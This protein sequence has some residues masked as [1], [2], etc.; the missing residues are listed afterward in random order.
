MQ[1]QVEV[2]I[3]SI[4]GGLP[5][6][7]LNQ[8]IARIAEDVARRSGI[9]KKRKVTLEITIV[10]KME[11]AGDAQVNMPEIDWGVSFSM[12]GASGATSRAIVRDGKVLVHPGEWT[13]PNQMTIP[14]VAPN[15]TRFAAQGEAGK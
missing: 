1:Q 4:Q 7:V 9:D 11:S 12:P 13:N 3:E 15:V 14:D 8:Y 10:P 5:L 2:D 6:Q